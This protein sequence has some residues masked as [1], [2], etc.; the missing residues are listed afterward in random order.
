V[1]D[2]RFDDYA[3]SRPAVKAW[4]EAWYLANS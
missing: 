1:P 2:E 4:L 3:A